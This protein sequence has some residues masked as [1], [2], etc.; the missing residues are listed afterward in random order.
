MVLA[1]LEQLQIRALF[2]QLSSSVSLRRVVLEMATDTAT[3]IRAS[4]VELCFCPA[5]YQGDSCQVGVIGDVLLQAEGGS[6]SRHLG[7]QPP[8]VLG[9]GG[10][11]GV[12]MSVQ[13][14]GARVP[15]FEST[16]EG[17]S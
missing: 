3:G 6:N 12:W 2:S 11:R 17:F 15:A 7:P 1:N 9:A 5:N 13:S 4:N 10:S 14:S 16:P 8:L